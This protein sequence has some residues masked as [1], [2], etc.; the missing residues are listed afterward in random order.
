MVVF[1]LYPTLLWTI[2]YYVNDFLRDID[3]LLWISKVDS[4]QNVHIDIMRNLSG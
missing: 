2:V 4:T 1:I 3:R